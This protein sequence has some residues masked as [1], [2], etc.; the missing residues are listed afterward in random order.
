LAD[1]HILAL[2]HLDVHPNGKFNLG[3]GR[4]VSNLELLRMVEKVSGARID[5]AFGPRRAGD[6]GVLVA[7]PRRAVER[8]GWSPGH[9]TLETIVQSALDWRRVHPQ[10]YGSG[11]GSVVER[12]GAL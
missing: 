8:L 1:A 4:A 6:P 11:A 10:G 12:A 9:S 3:A 2:R 7:S 5:F